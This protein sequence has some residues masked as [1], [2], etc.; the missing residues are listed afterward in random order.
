V[1]ICRRTNAQNLGKSILSEAVGKAFLTITAM[2]F[3]IS[4]LAQNPIPMVTAPLVPGQKNPGS[5]AFTLTVNGN[6]F[7]SGA[8]VNWNGNARTTTFFSN[9]QLTASINAADVATASTASITVVNPA[10]GGG[11]SNVAYFQVAKTATTAGFSKLDY[12]TDSSPQDVTTADFNG[13]GNLDL[14]VPTGNNTISILLGNGTGTFPT[15]TEYGVPGHPIAIATGDFNNDGKIDLVAVAGFLNQVSVLLGNGDGTF[16]AHV[17]YATGSHPSSVAVADVNGDGKLDLIVTDQNDNK[18]AVLLGNGDGTF[19]A[20]VDYA[21]GNAPAGVAVG[22][23]NGDGKLDLAVAANSDSM[24]AI[25]LGNGD[26]TFQ[27]PITFPTALNCNSVVTADFNGDGKLDL[28]V[29]TSNKALSVLLGNGD[30]TFQNHRDY[31]VGSNSVLVAA[32][33]LNAD[34]HLDLIVANANDNT[35]SV[36]LGNP[37]GTFKGESVFPTSAIPSGLTVG[38]FNNNGKLDI[39]VAASTANTVSILTDN[40]ITLTPSV[41][42]FGKQTSGFS[43]PAKSVTLKNTGSTAYTLGTTSFVGA[44]A[45]DFSET[46]TCAASIAPNGS[47]SISVV[48]TPTASETANAEMLIT[49]SNGSAL[50]IQMTG[51]GNIPITLSPRN[52]AFPNYQLIGTTSQAKL[53][54]FTNMSGVPITFSLIDSE[55]LNATDFPITYTCPVGSGSLAP[56]AS[57]TASMT[58]KPT[59]TGGE[60]TTLVF[61]GS[62]TLV[63]QGALVSGKGTAVKVTPVTVTFP[64]TTVGTTSAPQTVTFQNA[65]STAMNISSVVFTGVNAFNLVSNTCNF[66]GGSVPANSSCT[67]TLTFSPGTTGSISGT[68]KIGD[69]DPTGPQVVTLTGTGQ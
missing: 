60:T 34:S 35:V 14:A 54:T 51:N 3:S 42:G 20:H 59:I 38:D 26:G 45:S 61:Y 39:A 62:F 5:P 65:G 22:D 25:L 68:M 66:P 18:V 58:F 44:S 1:D 28:A 36:L 7:V 11:R 15:H 6:G 27:G 55:G 24:V 8:T 12:N 41:L 53:F 52:L 63:K 29:G 10:P 46:N 2:I 32:A 23:F 56:G 31:A 16:Q 37:D 50:G 64:A 40:A 30:G 57:C 9:K 49:A 19:Q 47:C 21:S 43:S 17:E 4:A 48:F 13:D 69:P 67:F 33:D